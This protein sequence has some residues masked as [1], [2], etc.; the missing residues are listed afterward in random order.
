MRNAPP[1]LTSKGEHL[2]GPHDGN[3]RRIA[4]ASLS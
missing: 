4:I 2:E 1:E 3:A